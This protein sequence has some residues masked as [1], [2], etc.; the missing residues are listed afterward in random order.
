MKQLMIHV[1]RAVRP[2]RGEVSTK[3]RMREEL[4]AHLTEILEEERERTGDENDAIGRACERFGDPATL[5]AELQTTVPWLQRIVCLLDDVHR[6]RPSETPLRHA[7]RVAMM[8]LLYF[9]VMW[10]ALILV[11]L[12]LDVMGV[13]P[14]A[15]RISAEHGLR[16]RLMVALGVWMSV[17]IGLFVLIGH[18]MRD[19]LEE[20]LL[21]PRSWRTAGVLS[22][23][24]VVIVFSCGG[25]FLLMMPIDAWAVSR[26]LPSWILA[27]LATPLIFAIVARLAA[28]EAV[29]SRPWTSLDI[30]D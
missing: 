27:A 3:C 21:R 19:Q 26:L 14:D 11:F 18:A 20:G 30:S 24:A 12:L 16:F 8:N 22:L 5:R 25:G 9:S 2:I 1:E 4:Y 6:R 17:A 7:V 10:A 23:L 29:R 15:H 13:G 28:I